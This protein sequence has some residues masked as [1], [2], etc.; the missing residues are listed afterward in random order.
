MQDRR[1]VLVTLYGAPAADPL[2]HADD[3]VSERQPTETW[4]LRGEPLTSTVR[5]GPDPS[6]R[7][8]GGTLVSRRLSHWC[9]NTESGEC[10]GIRRRSSALR[11]S[12]GYRNANSAG[13]TGASAPRGTA[14]QRDGG[15]W[16]RCNR[17]ALF[18][19]RWRRRRPRGGRARAAVGHQCPWQRYQS[20]RRYP[21]C[22]PADASS[23]P[24]RAGA[25]RGLRRVGP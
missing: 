15:H 8:C 6:E 20:Y 10:S 9:R 14:P 12:P 25:D 1:P 21:V 5:H 24:S 3:A 2:A 13:L 23:S 19:S 16:V 17:C 4:H 11:Q 18:L 7:H 22:A